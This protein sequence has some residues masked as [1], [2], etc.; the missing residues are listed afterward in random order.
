MQN[1]AVILGNNYYIGLS[2]IRCLGVK[3]IH[4]VA[5]DYSEE[6]RYG[7]KSKYCDEKIIVP[8]YQEE[9]DK[10]ISALIEYAK[11]QTK[12]PV[13]IPCHDS[14]L[15]V[16]DAFLDKIREY[17]FIP[18]TEQGL[19]RTVMNKET[20]HRLAKEHGVNVPETLSPDEENLHKKIKDTIKF[21]C[22]VKPVDSPSFVKE[23]R[24]K[25]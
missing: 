2:T 3:G 7:A 4:T 16:I 13:L 17:Y 18:Q 23:F 1:K 12:K 14:Y 21:P 8:H 6:N 25:L 5:A 11:Q 22:L 24:K 15:E 20:L 9:P 10:F 19:Y